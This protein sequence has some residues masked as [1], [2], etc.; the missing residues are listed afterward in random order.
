MWRPPM[1]CPRGWRNPHGLWL[2]GRG[3]GVC[4]AW[5]WRAGAGRWTFGAGMCDFGAGEAWALC[6]GAA[7]CALVAG[8][9]W[10]LWPAL[11]AFAC[12][13]AGAAG[14]EVEPCLPPC[15]AANV[16]ANAATHAI[17]ATMNFLMLLFIT[18]LHFLFLAVLREPV[19]R[20]HRVRGVSPR[21]LTKGQLEICL[22]TSF[23]SIKIGGKPIEEEKSI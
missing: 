1:W 10:V 11:G 22:R 21:L 20:L 8:C 12:W 6:A 3:G 15:G 17:P 2:A 23:T 14:R 16:V 9:A 4:R 18:H 13:R 7:L 5:A 19:S